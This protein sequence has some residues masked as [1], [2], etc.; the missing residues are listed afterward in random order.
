MVDEAPLES[1]EGALRHRAGVEHETRDP[2]EAFAG[3]LDDVPS[4]YHEGWL[5][6]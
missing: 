1:I 4:G 3:L 2:A 6:G 5:P